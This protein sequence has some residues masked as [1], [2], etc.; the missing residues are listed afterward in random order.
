VRRVLI[1][2]AGGR[3]F[4]DF[5]VVYRDDPTAGL[6][7]EVQTEDLDWNHSHT[8]IIIVRRADIQN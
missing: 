6:R 1:M 8:S 4:H 2:G 3:D 7:I 5:D